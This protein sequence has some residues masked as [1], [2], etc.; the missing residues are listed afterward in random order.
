LT[1]TAG[2]PTSYSYDQ[3]S[4]LTSVDGPAAATYRYDG[5]GLRTSK[6]VGGATAHN[7]WNVTD[8]VPTLLADG[9]NYYIY[10]PDGRPVEHI[11]TAGTVAYYHGDQLGSTRLLTNASGVSVGSYSYDAYGTLTASSGS[12]V[13]PLGFAGEYRD[14]ETGLLYLRARYYDPASAQF[15]TRDPL[16]AITRQPYLYAD[17]DPLNRIDPRGLSAAGDIVD[18]TFGPGGIVDDVTP[19]VLSNAAA[20]YLDGWSDGELSGAFGIDDW[21]DAPGYGFGNKAS[22]V[23]PKGAVKGGL[24]LGTRAFAK[25]KSRGGP[26]KAPTGPKRPARHRRKEYDPGQTPGAR[27][28]YRKRPPGHRGPWPPRQ[29]LDGH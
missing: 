22:Y 11:T 29:L 23:N 25:K 13:T 12:A 5:D 14:A 20:G 19:D 15:L 4:R 1:P 26:G 10:G 24:K 18:A 17:G 27:D 2:Q 28:P 9:S 3:A 16:E 6:T 8:D 7:V 21:C